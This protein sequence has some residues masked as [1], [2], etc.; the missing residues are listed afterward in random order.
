[1]GNGLDKYDLTG[2]VALITGANTHGIGKGCLENKV[3]FTRSC[4]DLAHV[5]QNTL[6]GGKKEN[7]FT[8]SPHG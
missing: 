8:T 3:F 1:M 5:L 4:K 2:R 7:V 6:A